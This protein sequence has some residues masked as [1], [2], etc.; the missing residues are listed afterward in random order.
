MNDPNNM[1]NMKIGVDICSLKRIDKAYKRFGERFLERVLTE[2][3]IK[4]VSS[5]PK[6]LISRLAA[7]FAAKEAVVK[8]LGTGW[9]GVGFQEV[10]VARLKSGEPFLK[11]HNRAKKRADKLGLSQFKISMSHEKEFAVAFVVAY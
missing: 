1:N 2:N 7:R 3:E 10:E 4:Y 11:L 9:Y 8:A 6:H 5:A